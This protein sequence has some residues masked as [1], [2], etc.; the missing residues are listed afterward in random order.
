MRSKEDAFGAAKLVAI[1]CGVMIGIFALDWILPADLRAYGIWPRDFGGLLGI[2]AGPFLHSNLSHLGSNLPVFALLAFLC[3]IK[4]PRYFLKASALI[5]LM[6]GMLVWL[7]ARGGT[8]HIG[9]S[10]WIFGLWSLAIALA[11]FERS[12]F[13]IVIATGVVFFYGGMVYGVLP[14]QSYIS[15]ESHLFGAISGVVAAY[16]LHRP[17]RIE[18][19]SQPTP[20]LKFWPGEERLKK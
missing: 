15:F 18:T 6:T 10:G 2:A 7:F 8:T 3:L 1:L 20:S 11:W 13:S 12:F 16:A 19:L 4:G 9:A 17:A 5:I 14:T